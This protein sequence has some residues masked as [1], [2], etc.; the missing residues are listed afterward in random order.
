VASSFVSE[1][2]L[3][4]HS[5]CTVRCV[6][7]HALIALNGDLE[8]TE[9]G[10]AAGAASTGK[11]YAVFV[12]LSRGPSLQPDDSTTEKADLAPPLPLASPG[13]LAQREETFLGIVALVQLRL[14]L[15]AALQQQ[16]SDGIFQLGQCRCERGPAFV[17]VGQ[18]PAEMAP[19]AVLRCVIACYS[20]P[21]I[22]RRM[23]ASS[24]EIDTALA[25]P[26][27]APPA[28]SNSGGK[29]AP[30]RAQITSKDPLS[31]I[32]AMPPPAL[33]ESQLQFRRGN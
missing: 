15:S 5:G 3:Q 18:F 25:L 11:A 1:S 19:T 17:S 20:L 2:S 12:V 6:E 29:G 21:L 14:D 26:G 31:W 32:S 33:R 24:I 10:F 8:T 28:T 16:L 30:P 23:S 4:H 22:Q 13:V 9:E 7:T 27:L